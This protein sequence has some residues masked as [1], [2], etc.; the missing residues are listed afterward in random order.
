MSAT[1]LAACQLCQSAPNLFAAP[2]APLASSAPS[3]LPACT[4]PANSAAASQARAPVSASVRM[5]GHPLGYRLYRIED[6][7]QR[8][9]Q[10][11]QEVDGRENARQHHV[12]TFGGLQ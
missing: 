1:S 10:E 8:H 2:S 3:A 6:G 12:Q 5:E 7:V 9:Q 4:A 11:E